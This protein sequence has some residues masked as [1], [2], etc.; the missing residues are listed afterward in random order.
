[1]RQSIN[2]S[3]GRGLKIIDSEMYRAEMALA[4]PGGAQKL[5]GMIRLEK[6]LISA[7]SL[8]KGASKS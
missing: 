2:S 4:R 6:I 7:Y 5:G 1:M 8:R 3:V